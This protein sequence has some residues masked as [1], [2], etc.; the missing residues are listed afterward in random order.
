M[1]CLVLI[2]SKLDP[3]W[4]SAGVIP[5]TG[6]EEVDIEQAGRLGV[7]HSEAEKKWVYQPDGEDVREC[8]SIKEAALGLLSFK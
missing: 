7:K 3:V 1:T 8:V 2:R 5:D 4:G 6:R